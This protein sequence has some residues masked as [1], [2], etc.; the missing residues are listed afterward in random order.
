MTPQDE[1]VE[2]V[3]RAIELAL[4]G[5]ATEDY[6]WIEPGF[7]SPFTVKIDGGVSL[8]RLARAAIEA[9]SAYGGGMGREIVTSDCSAAQVDGSAMHPAS[10]GGEPVAWHCVGSGDGWIED[11]IIR[12]AAGAADYAKRPHQ[13]NVRPLVYA[14][15]PPPETRE[16]AIRAD[17]REACAEA[18]RAVGDEAKQ[19]GYSMA[20]SRTGRDKANA[21]AHAA[22]RIEIAIRARG[23]S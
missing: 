17:E 12:D 7:A 2:R 20:K 21:A 11:K 15:P 6:A 18:A 3:A 4:M 9:I 16:A 22:A 13:W 14:S 10:E 1:M 5:H 8:E 23:Q 19:R